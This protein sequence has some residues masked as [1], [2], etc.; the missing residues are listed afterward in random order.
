MQ[1]HF[2]WLQK[3][4]QEQWESWGNATGSCK[5]RWTV[6]GC[7]QWS[8]TTTQ[9]WYATPRYLW[10]FF[11]LQ[12]MENKWVMRERWDFWQSRELCLLTGFPFLLSFCDSCQ[13]ISDY[14]NAFNM[15]FCIS[16]S[17]VLHFVLSSV[18]LNYCNFVLQSLINSYS[19]PFSH[20]RPIELKA[21]TPA[22]VNGVNAGLK[23]PTTH[24]WLSTHIMALAFMWLFQEIR[25][26]C[27][28]KKGQSLACVERKE[29]KADFITF[30]LDLVVAS[31]QFPGWFSAA[32]FW[33]G[34]R[35]P[36]LLASASGQQE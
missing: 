22:V 8:R 7:L 14:G 2:Y 21:M 11:T 34:I 1:L 4:L 6:S 18:A 29:N 15:P 20:F 13:L 25:L 3:P 23:Y 30:Y 28:L 31:V 26:W 24:K 16:L 27:E 5:Q 9:R 32:C 12:S 10:G 17:L 19:V 35:C 33:V 36:C